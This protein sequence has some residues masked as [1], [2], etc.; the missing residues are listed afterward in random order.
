MT[1]KR[2]VT[3]ARR[4]AVIV[5]SGPSARGFV[6]PDDVTVIAV[7]GAI[8]W[9]SRADYF[10]TL[11]P[12]PENYRRLKER[13]RGV[14]YCAAGPVGRIPGVRCFERIARRGQEP[15]E[16]YTPAWWLW[17][18]SAVAG[19][20]E[21]RRQI[22]TGNSAYGALGLAYHLGFTD[23]ALQG[24]DGT[25]EARIEG[26]QPGNLSHLPLLFESALHQIRV[27]SCGKLTGIP[28]MHF[29]DWLYE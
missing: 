12:S 20:S 17:R 8:E 21:N 11:D 27:V 6:P 28:Q 22:H 26:G 1:R 14:T 10:F 19:L 13:R 15:R 23:V 3:P 9:L 4:K 24:V 5:A 2:T 25:E 29:K 18:W 16:R 7:N